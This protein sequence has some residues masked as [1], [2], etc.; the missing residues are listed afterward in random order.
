MLPA[1]PQLPPRASDAL[2]MSTGVP[3]STA[4]FFSLPRAKNASH[5]PSGDQNGS[6]ANSGSGNGAEFGRT[7]PSNE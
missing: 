1:R 6:V 7:E 5:C 2:Q 4:T 3:R